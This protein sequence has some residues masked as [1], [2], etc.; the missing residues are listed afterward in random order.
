MLIYIDLNFTHN[1]YFI[2]FLLIAIFFLGTPNNYEWHKRKFLCNKNS[3]HSKAVYHDTDRLSTIYQNFSQ[4]ENLYMSINSVEGSRYPS[5]VDAFANIQ[6][7]RVPLHGITTSNV[8]SKF[9][10]QYLFI[11]YSYFIYPYLFMYKVQIQTKTIFCKPHN[12]G[13]K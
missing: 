4:N 12:Q 3:Y 11:L 13:I 8:I 10:S 5:V 7:Q 6:S 1:E 9:I 2:D